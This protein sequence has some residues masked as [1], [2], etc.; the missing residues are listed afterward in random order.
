M[1]KIDQVDALIRIVRSVTDN[2]NSFFKRLTS[3]EVNEFLYD[4]EILMYRFFFGKENPL[5]FKWCL[6]LIDFYSWC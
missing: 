3:P 6:F 4:I 5:C 2:I 1:Y